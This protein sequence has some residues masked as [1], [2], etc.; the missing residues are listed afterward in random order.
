MTQYHALHLIKG[1]VDHLLAPDLA[2][3][4]ASAV[5]ATLPAPV[6]HVTSTA[7]AILPV[8]AE[9][10]GEERH[11][12]H[13]HGHA[14]HTS[15]APPAEMAA[16]LAAAPQTPTPTGELALPES[17]GTPPVDAASVAALVNEV[18]IEQAR[19]HGVDLS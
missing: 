12:G 10:L 11:A 1:Q 6:A 13:Q 15:M 3:H 4:V 19:R 2:A 9:A 16:G 18:L 17:A 5:A 8:P 7:A 14:G